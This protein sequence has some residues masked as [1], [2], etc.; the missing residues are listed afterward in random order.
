MLNLLP[1]LKIEKN[2]QKIY[3][4]AKKYPKFNIVS[5]I[6]LEEELSA[7]RIALA[8]LYYKAII[9]HPNMGVKETTELSLKKQQ[10]IVDIVDKVIFKDE[11][12]KAEFDNKLD[13]A[14]EKIAYEKDLESIYKELSTKVYKI[15]DKNSDTK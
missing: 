12:E 15:Y 10:E 14:D 6:G 13:I 3:L 9:L 4:P 2:N 11:K 1:N 8:Y 7:P 5:V